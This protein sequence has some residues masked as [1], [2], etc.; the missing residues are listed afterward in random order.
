MTTIHDERIATHISRVK[1]YL[2]KFAKTDFAAS[3][4]F[5]TYDAIFQSIHHDKDKVKG[6]RNY[7]QYCRIS[8]MY[9]CKLKGVPC[10]IEY[11]SEMDAAT[12]NH[13]KTNAHHPEYWDLNY[14]P[15]AVT[16]FSNRD[17]TKLQSVS[18]ERMDS[19][20]IV[21]MV[22]D[23]RATGDERGNKAIVWAEKCKA[24]RR[25]VF[26]DNQW[27]LIYDVILIIDTIF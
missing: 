11:T 5:T 18:G 26:T 3:F 9:D 21:E 4:N 17:N 10:E 13:V 23:W 20:S 15:V 8:Y 19:K 22:C 12:V 7:E 16:D 24:D 1:H 6:G 25:Y 14:K 27:D 2:Y